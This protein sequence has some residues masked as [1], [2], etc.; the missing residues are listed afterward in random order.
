MQGC[1]MSFCVVFC[2][3]PAA[4]A[5]TFVRLSCVRPDLDHRTFAKKSVTRARVCSVGS[6]GTT[7]GKHACSLMQASFASS[8]ARNK[9]KRGTMRPLQDPHK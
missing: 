3:V 1:S 7:W 8:G 4:P 6:P 2:C 9:K 5:G